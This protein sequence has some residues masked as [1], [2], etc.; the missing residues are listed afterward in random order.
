MDTGLILTSTDRTDAP[1][2]QILL[3]MRT[4]VGGDSEILGFAAHME[5]LAIDKGKW[6]QFFS[7]EEISHARRVCQ[8]IIAN[9]E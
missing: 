8:L 2:N 1:T 6:D 3:N 4:T 5:L 7:P 9:Q